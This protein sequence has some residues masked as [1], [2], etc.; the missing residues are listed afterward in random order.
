MQ[1]AFE[2]YPQVDTPLTHRFTNGMYSR[3]IFMPAGTLVV[4]RQHKTEHQYVVLTGKVMVNV[5]GEGVKILE[6][7]HVGIT[8][9]GTRRALYIIEDCKWITF[10]PTKETDLEKL[11]DE[12]TFTPDVGYVENDPEALDMMAELHASMLYLGGPQ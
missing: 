7:G 4:S 12:L 2:D 9:P 5:P 11:Q 1:H 8:K 10:H 3:E 6:A